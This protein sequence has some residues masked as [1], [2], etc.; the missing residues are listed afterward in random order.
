MSGRAGLEVLLLP[1]DLGLLEADQ[2]LL[3]PGRSPV[4]RL[5]MRNPSLSLSLNLFASPIVL[6]VAVLHHRLLSQHDQPLPGLAP[7]TVARL[8][9]WPTSA[10]LVLLSLGS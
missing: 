5:S 3:D 1:L 9:P 10:F 6:P 7:L 2:T 4:T 8:H